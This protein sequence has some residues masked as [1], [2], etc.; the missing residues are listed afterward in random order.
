MSCVFFMGV[1]SYT[2]LK[3]D[4]SMAYSSFW[5]DAPTASFLTLVRY[6]VNTRYIGN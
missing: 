3:T 1:D 6:H 4:V 2:V 5:P